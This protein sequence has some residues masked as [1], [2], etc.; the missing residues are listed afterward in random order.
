[1]HK[2]A[3]EIQVPRMLAIKYRGDFR[4]FS[5]PWQY[6]SKKNCQRL[7]RNLML[8]WQLLW[9]TL[10]FCQELCFGFLSD[11]LFYVYTLHCLIIIHLNW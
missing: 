8:H 4:I 9:H 10:A 3:F 5:L 1:M 11:H 7:Y 2:T 6:V